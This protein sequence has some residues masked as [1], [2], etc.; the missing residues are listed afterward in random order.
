MKPDIN[1]NNIGR[2]ELIRKL[3]A[4]SQGSVLLAR[5]PKLDRQVAIKLLS[6]VASDLN[7]QTEDGTPIE[8]RTSSKLKHPNI[9]P[10][11]DAGRAPQ[12]PYL[13]FEFVDGVPLANLLRIEKKYALERAIPL[14]KAILDAMAHAH[15]AEI[16]HLDL[17]PRNILVGEDG[18]PRIMDFGLA[19]YINFTRAPG[20]MATGTLHYMAP[21]HMV[22]QPL[23]SWTDVFAL[24]TTFY[25]LV[26]GRRPFDGIQVLDI[27]HKIAA[28][29]VDMAPVLALPHGELLAR[30]LAGALERDREGRYRDAPVMREAFEL[31]LAEAGLDGHSADEAPAHSTIDFLMRR[32]QRKKDFPAISKTLSDINRLTEAGSSASADK[33]ANVILRDLAL[34][35]KLL[36]LVNSAYYGTRSAEVSSISQAVV[37][38]GVKQ[39]RL[40]ANS[41]TFFGHLRSDSEELKDSMT[42]SFL[43]G[44]IARELAKHLR[45]KDAEEAFICGL[46][47]NLGENLAMYYFAEDHADIRELQHAKRLDKT[48]ASRGVLG[49]SFA[50]LGAA[51][52]RVW[53]LPKSIIQAIRGMPAAVVVEPADDAAKLR[54]L[55]VFANLVCDALQ[56][57]DATLSDQQ[58]DAVLQ[59]F[60]PSIAL[61]RDHCVRLLIAVFE[62]LVE[63]APIFEISVSSSRYCRSVQAWLAAQPAAEEL[64]TAAAG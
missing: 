5:D 33:L 1:N 32:M 41:L 61:E 22:Q 53:N 58:L 52:A 14:I 26:T 50:E 54:D 28:A 21:E 3:G 11:F 8:A 25:E 27:Q 37:I 16:L 63:Y 46:C 34:T 62:K 36:T 55:A 4:G 35:S 47:Q 2:Y 64:E 51:V 48:A 39:I 31:F 19:Q 30:F 57:D 49:V 45:L 40:T 24:G 20:E 44:L 60:A 6:D 9:I 12:G 59:R 56:Q 42:R 38:L 17:S 43:S 13:V 18:I 10:I 15:S 23:G 7:L 29:K